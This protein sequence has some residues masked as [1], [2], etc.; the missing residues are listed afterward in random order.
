VIP[1]VTVCDIVVS[2]TTCGPLEVYGLKAHYTS[3]MNT[4]SFF[5]LERAKMSFIMIK[6][7][8]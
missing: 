3:E 7:W 8:L 6:K 4:F 1:T 5:R 2:G